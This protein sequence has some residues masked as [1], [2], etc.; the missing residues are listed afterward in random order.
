MENIATSPDLFI[1]S[2]ISPTAKTKILTDLNP[3]Y[4][5]ITL[6]AME[7]LR[8]RDRFGFPC[9]GVL[10]KPVNYRVG[11][12]YPLVVMT[13][14]WGNSFIADTDFQTAFPPQPLANA[15]FLV[16]L[17]S[18]P[19][20]DEIRR[21]RALQRYPGEIGEAYE[22]MSLVESGVSLL[23]A[24]GLADRKCV[25]IMGF[26][27][28]S[29]AT[30]F[31]LTHS[32]FPFL[33]AS[34]A[35]GG[36]YNYGFDWLHNRQDLAEVDAHMFGGP[37]YGHTFERWLRNAPAFNA[38]HVRTPLLMEYI[39]ANT[40]SGLEFFAALTRQNKAVELFW[41][42]NGQHVLDTPFERV[43]S[44]QRNVDW[45]RFWMQGYEG[46]PPAYDPDQFLRWRTLR[47]DKA[48]AAGSYNGRGHSN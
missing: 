44:L 45:F 34:S 32:D 4:R 37:P 41:Y 22:F 40:L 10:I 21:N 11:Q 24:R 9:K 2:L 15:G 6:G 23:G 8:W 48:T 17:A 35:D 30:D 13:K 36:N 46:N 19:G 5:A 42:P 18:V 43:A 31:M 28:T 47:T 16:L 25:G 39:G 38:G 1:H 26:S 27:H 14:G 12:R 29:W 33:A 20:L 7:E 3:N